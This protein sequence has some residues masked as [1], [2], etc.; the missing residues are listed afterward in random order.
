MPGFFAKVHCASKS[1]ID[2]C[3]VGFCKNPMHPPMELQRTRKEIY[4]AAVA[5]QTGLQGKV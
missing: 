2:P 5:R 3:T 4:L 1:K